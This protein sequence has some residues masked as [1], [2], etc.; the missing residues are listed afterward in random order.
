M[1]PHDNDDK[2]TAPIAPVE[3]SETPAAPAPTPTPA[4]PPVRSG[5]SGG[6]A[7]A[8]GLVASVLVLGAAA[9]GAYVTMPQWQPKLAEQMVP[10]EAISGAQAAAA[11]AQR[12]AEAVDGKLAQVGEALGSL[13][14]QLGT[15]EKAI[16]ASVGG[17]AVDPARVEA[18]S[19]R[20]AALE[21]LPRFDPAQLAALR[22]TLDGLAG[23]LATLRKEMTAFNGLGAELKQ[24]NAEFKQDFKQAWTEFKDSAVAPSQVLKLAERIDAAEAAVQQAQ[25]RTQQAQAL[26]IATGQLREAIYRG[27]PFEAELR[28]LKLIAGGDEQMAKPLAALDGLAG[29]GVA[30]RGELSSRFG[31]LASDM[32]RAEVA[33]EESGWWRQTVQAVTSVITIRRLDGEAAGD[34]VS[35]RVARAAE[36]LDKGDLAGTVRELSGLDGGPAAVAAPWLAKAQARLA[37]EQALSNLT[38]HA[39]A[40][41][42]AKG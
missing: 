29:K 39:V 37:A 2:D 10:K 6:G 25:S 24:A 5:I 12:Q 4:S 22:Q 18:L 9:G 27:A 8:L 31:E 20:I 26:L 14:T 15:I 42:Q 1:S 35:A 11:K 21:T 33:P 32:I 38:A 41:A 23:E 19:T 28:S 30:T 36:A 13:R 17:A 40:V 16:P 3:R 7:F 34:S